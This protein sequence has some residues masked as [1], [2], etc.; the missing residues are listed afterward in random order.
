MGTWSDWFDD[1]SPYGPR[2]HRRRQGAHPEG[3]WPDPRS[4]FI[5]GALA[6][7]EWQATC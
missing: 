6:L 1:G 7:R 2:S 4:R 3:L 5:R